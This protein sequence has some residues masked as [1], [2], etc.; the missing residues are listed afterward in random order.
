MDDIFNQQ[1]LY[2]ILQGRLRYQCGD[3]VLYIHEPTRDI[4][5]ESFVI[6]DEAY[7]N[8]YFTGVYLKSELVEILVSNDLWTPFDDREAEKIEKQIEEFKIQAFKSFFKT[9]ELILIKRGLRALEKQLIKYRSKKICLDY[10]SCEGVAAFSQ[11]VWTISNTTKDIEGNLYNWQHITPLS[12]MKHYDNSQISASTFRSIT[13]NEP[14]RSMWANGKQQS[15]IFGKPT[16]DLTRDQLSLCSYAMMYDN[17]Y[18]S[19]ETPDDNVI[20][21]D[22]CLDGWFIVQ[23]RK[24]EKDRKKRETEDLLSNP[25]IANSQ[26]VFVMT[27][28]QESADKL[29]DLND[30]VSRGVVQSRQQLHRSHDGK[31]DFREFADI[32]QD[33]ALAQ[34]QAAIH[35]AKGGR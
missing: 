9:K 32:K 2:R 26:E 7:K 25:K 29:Y 3:L 24:Q 13:R 33:I 19:M 28:D 31:L 22:D 10:V 6:Y 5:E 30:P 16:C 34:T 12:V 21:D 20:K 23:R 14:W 35:K 17:V 15:N 8:A 4:I 11:S 1:A 18:E 27:S